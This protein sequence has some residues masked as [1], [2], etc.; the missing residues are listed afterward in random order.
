MVSSLIGGRLGANLARRISGET[1]RVAIA[2]LGL[3]VAAVL[4]VRVFG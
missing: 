2:L 3:V 1:L 4:G